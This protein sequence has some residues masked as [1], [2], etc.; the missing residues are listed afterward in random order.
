MFYNRKV[1]VTLTTIPSRFKHIKYVL[2]SLL[3]QSIKPDEIVLSLPMESIREPC[4]GDPYKV[5]EKITEELN[6]MG[7]T[8]WRTKRDYGPATKLL[9]LL[10]REMP[11]KLDKNKEALIITVDD[12]KHYYKD[13]V[14]NLLDGW[15]RN[16]DCVVCRKGSVIKQLSRKDKTYL[17]KK[18]FFDKINR[19]HEM[20]Y[21]GNQVKQ[22][23]ELS[24]VF[25]TG[26]VLYKASFFDETVFDYKK[27]DSSFPDKEIFL[28]DDV[29]LSGYLGK[30]GIKKK[31]IK[32]ESNKM[33]SKIEEQKKGQNNTNLDDNTVSRTV[34]PLVDINKKDK[35][36]ELLT[37]SLKYYEKYM[38]KVN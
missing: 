34:N 23:T 14:K 29:Y 31:V 18:S 33:I 10:E 19:Y 36:L 38:I 27:E 11:K 3:Q 26:G 30:K 24:V 16:M 7:V 20:V 9:G 32:F 35:S 37:K 4:E 12:D 5:D 21:L 17:S 28:T 2:V 8:I 6:K 25:G 1:I 15:K 22:D 13:C